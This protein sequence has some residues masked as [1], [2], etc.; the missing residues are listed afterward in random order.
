MQQPTTELPGRADEELRCKLRYP[1]Q[2]AY[3]TRQNQITGMKLKQINDYYKSGV[4][5]TVRFEHIFYTEG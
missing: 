3:K 2:E 5:L 1:P 4:T